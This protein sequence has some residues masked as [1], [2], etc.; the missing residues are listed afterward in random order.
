MA[1]PGA[2]PGK[3]KTEAIR[4]SINQELVRA[5]VASYKK[6][7][8]AT[9][10]IDFGTKAIGGTKFIKSAT[11]LINSEMR[12]PPRTTTAAFIRNAIAMAE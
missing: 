8:T 4:V 5:G 2:M 12:V 11:F 3:S 7:K 1:K 9:N 6:I 10:P